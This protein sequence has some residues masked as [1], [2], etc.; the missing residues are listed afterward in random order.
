MNPNGSG[1][2]TARHG[3]RFVAE[4]GSVAA[5]GSKVAPEDQGVGELGRQAGKALREQQ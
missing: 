1:F 5:A 4:T 3:L 2:V